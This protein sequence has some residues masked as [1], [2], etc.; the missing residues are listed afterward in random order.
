M[1][2]KN[3]GNYAKIEEY[4]NSYFDANACPPEGMEIAA[5]LGISRATVTRYLQ[6]MAQA[7]VIVY[8]NYRRP[9]T[10]ATAKSSLSG[11]FVPIVGR[12]PC[13][14][15]VIAE[16]YTEG[17]IRLPE[18]LTGSGE[19]FLLRASGSSM[20]G[21]GIDSGDLVLIRKQSVAEPGKIVAALVDGSDATLK[22][23]YPEPEKG[24]IRLHPENTE[25]ED[26]YYADCTV[27]GVAV[28]VIKELE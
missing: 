12:I 4:I 28:R 24:R 11:S 15:P 22:R 20:T 13:G 27:M 1:R 16:E 14:S 19:F 23:Y 7:G 17:Y 6:D 5:A 2:T 10:S 26:M 25:M 21:A 8:D 3:T 18:E 9:L